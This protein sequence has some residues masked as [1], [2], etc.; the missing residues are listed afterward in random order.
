MDICEAK[1]D[2]PIAEAGLLPGE[3]DGLADSCGDGIA[4]IIGELMR[5]KCGEGARGM[6]VASR[7]AALWWISP[8][9]R[10]RRFSYDLELSRDGSEGCL[11]GGTR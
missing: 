10:P 1:G 5:I 4:R 3:G 7:P 9:E 11:P 8:V 6:V 2:T